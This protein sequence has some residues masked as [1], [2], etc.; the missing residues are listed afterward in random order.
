MN[1]EFIL[2][3]TAQPIWLILSGRLADQDNVR[4]NIGVGTALS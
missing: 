4:H 3:D 2:S 1:L